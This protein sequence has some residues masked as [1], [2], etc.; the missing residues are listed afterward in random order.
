MSNVKVRPHLDYTGRGGLT[1]KEIFGIARH[2]DRPFEKAC[3]DPG[4]KI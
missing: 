3:F 2:K 4:V 1:L